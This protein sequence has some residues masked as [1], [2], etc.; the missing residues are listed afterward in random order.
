[1]N[2]LAQFYAE[3]YRLIAKSKMIIESIL[4]RFIKAMAFKLIEVLLSIK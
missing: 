2:I 3:Y 4:I 1:M